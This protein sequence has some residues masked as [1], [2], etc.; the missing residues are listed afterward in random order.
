MLM[1]NRALTV[2]CGI[3]LCALVSCSDYNKVLKTS[4]YG[5]KYEVAKQSYAVGEY[6]RASVLLR[7]VIAMLKGTE[8]GEASLFLLGMSYFKAEDYEAAAEVFKKYYETYP[9]GIYAE[10]ARFHTGLSLYHNVPEPKLDQTA[11][12][13]ALTEFQ[14]FLEEHP[15]SSYREEVQRLIFDL[16]D[17]LVEKEYL[18]AKMYYDLG[19]YFG[20]CTNG[21]NNFQACIVTAQNAISDYPYSSR[22]ENFAILILKAKFELAAQS[23]LDKQEERYHNAIDEY[24]GFCNEYPESTFMPQAKELYEKAKRYVKN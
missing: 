13:E 23:V 3:A 6:N 22:R 16:Q 1:R 18:N 11:T 21:G 12:Y 7:E 20:N 8:D 17:V 9:R 2:I 4:D 5:L 15:N 19:T 10:E 14:N 24:Y